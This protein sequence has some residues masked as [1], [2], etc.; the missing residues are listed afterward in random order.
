MAS[1]QT[2]TYSDTADEAVRATCDDASICKRFATSKGYWTDL[3]A[4]YFVR[5]IGERKAPEINRGYYGRVK[6]VNLLLDAFLE[7]TQYS[8]SLDSDRYCIIAADLR[9]LPTLE[10]KLKKFQINPELPT[11]FLSECVLVYMTPEQSSKL[12]HWVADTFPTAMFINYEQVNMNDRFGHIMIENL[13]RRQCNLAGVDLCQSLDSQK[14]RFLSA[15][16]ESVNALDMMMVYSMLPQEDVARIE[17]LEFLDEKE[18]LQQLLQHYCICWAVKDKL[19][20]EHLKLRTNKMTS[21]ESKSELFTVATGDGG[22]NHQNTPKKSFFE[23]YIQ[24]CLAEIV[25]STLFMF[26][27]CVSVM[28]NVGISGSI[29]PALAHGLALAIAIA[30]FGEISGGHFNPAV[31]VCVYLIGG[32]ELILLV[33]YVLS[34]MLG[35]VIAAGLAKAVTTNEAFGNA[36][37]AAFDAIQ[38]AHGTGSATMAEMIMTLFLTM[39]VS[40]G[41]VNG[42]T[43]SHLAPFC[44]GLTVTAN[45]LAG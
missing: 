29:Q 27:G 31:S 18:L 22:D 6:G 44:I 17:R 26:V 36:T 1:K 16:W 19:S 2:F 28:G 7:K 38:S 35:G 3:Y 32:M 14:E 30:I 9:D 37:G 23:H 8:H 4:Q 43:R 42:R 10:D 15:G 40:M 12:V 20:L 25:G 24:P 33:P 21:V 13:Q 41:A 11:L 34:Q 45:I 39:V 5:Q